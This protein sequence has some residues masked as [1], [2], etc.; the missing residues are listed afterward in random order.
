MRQL[1]AIIGSTFDD[2]SNFSSLMLLIDAESHE[3]HMTM[4]TG[5]VLCERLIAICSGWIPHFDMAG[6]KRNLNIDEI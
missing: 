6:E 3:G 1:S 5:G 2:T 4:K